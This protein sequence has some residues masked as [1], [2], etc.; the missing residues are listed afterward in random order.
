[1]KLLKRIKAAIACMCF[2]ALPLKHSTFMTM[3]LKSPLALDTF[4][5]FFF[6]FSFKDRD[7][8]MVRRRRKSHD[9]MS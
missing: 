1:M 7:G 4:D 8:V 2:L 6:F 9:Y 3:S 5:S